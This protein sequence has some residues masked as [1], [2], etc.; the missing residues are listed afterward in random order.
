MASAFKCDVCGS[1]FELQPLKNFIGGD[2]EVNIQP[3]LRLFMFDEHKNKTCD[4][5]EWDLCPECYK[6]LRQFLNPKVENV[7]SE[8]NTDCFEKEM[9]QEEAFKLLQETWCYK[10][11]G[12]G[13]DGVCKKRLPRFGLSC[14]DAFMS[15][16]IPK[17][18][19]ELTLCSKEVKSGGNENEN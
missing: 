18:F 13:S 16:E 2:R 14:L 1:F 19:E 5:E 11:K 4:F 7:Q 15:N 3:N 17:A 8:N 9:T 12:L 6:K 10:C